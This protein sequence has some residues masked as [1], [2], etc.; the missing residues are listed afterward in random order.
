MCLGA[1]ACVSE[2]EASATPPLYY[3]LTTLPLPLYSV[4][5]VDVRKQMVARDA[6]SLFAMLKERHHDNVEL[7]E[8]ADVAIRNLQPTT[9]VGMSF[10][11]TCTR[12]CIRLLMLFFF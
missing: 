5:L 6:A 10:F 7:Q 11:A 8:I 2:F 12:M 1:Y 3:I 9:T 4:S